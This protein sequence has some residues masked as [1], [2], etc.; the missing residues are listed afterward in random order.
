MKLLIVSTS[1]AP[2]QSGKAGGVVD[3][4]RYLVR[5]LLNDFNITL[6]VPSGSVVDLPVNVIECEGVCSPPAQ[7]EDV[8]TYH[9]E[10]IIYSYRAYIMDNV[11]QYDKILNFSFDLPIFLSPIHICITM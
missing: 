6:L 11:D 5:A 8:L 10:S 2:F 9:S 1:V 4:I 7:L 3:T